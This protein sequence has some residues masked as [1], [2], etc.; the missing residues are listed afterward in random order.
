[1]AE[2]LARVLRGHGLTACPAGRISPAARPAG[3]PEYG[4]DASFTLFLRHGGGIHAVSPRDG[5]ERERNRSH[6]SGR[7]TPGTPGHP[8]PRVTRNP[9][10]S[11][12]PLGSPARND[13]P[14]SRNPRRKEFASQNTS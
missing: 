2:V 13:P 14:P 1:M 6:G 12:E 8:E 9:R 4:V 10:V 7:I 3:R 5:R 11:L